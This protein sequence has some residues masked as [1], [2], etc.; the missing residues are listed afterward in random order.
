MSNSPRIRPIICAGALA[1]Y[2]FFTA[3]PSR[4]KNPRSCAAQIGHSSGLFNEPS[5]MPFS[6]F[7]GAASAGAGVVGCC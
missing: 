6:G 3:S 2:A 4:A 5:V 7:A 1:L